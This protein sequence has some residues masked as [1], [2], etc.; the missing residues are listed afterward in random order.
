VSRPST[1]ASERAATI[2]KQ[3][4]VSA[5]NLEGLKREILSDYTPDGWGLGRFSGIKNL[6]DR[7]VA[8]DLA[9]SSLEGVNTSLVALGLRHAHYKRLI[10]PNGR[11]MPGPEST[12]EDHLQLVELDVCA[13][14]C[15]RAFGSVLD[16]LTAVAVLLTGVPL[17]VQR[18]E[19]TW[20]LRRPDQKKRPSDRSA[21]ESAW[22]SIA[23]VVID[24]GNRPA[25]GWL[26]WALEM[27][28]AVMHR[29]QLL[30]VWLNRP[31]ERRPGVPP[32]LVRTDM[33]PGVPRSDGTSPAPDALATRHALTHVQ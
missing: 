28:N 15:F 5:P 21:Q 29:G 20:F 1:P 19:G 3:F 12:V 25:Q 13:T 4:G 2:A 30:R 18:T 11:T 7:A 24:E 33:D 6:T 31:S 16:C 17:K 10:G 23:T 26:A 22:D 27:R 9:V 32:L 14:D 8:S